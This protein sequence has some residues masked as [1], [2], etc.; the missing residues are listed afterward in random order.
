MVVEITATSLVRL[1]A[2]LQ[3]TTDWR[4]QYKKLISI[5]V[6]R[7]LLANS[8]YR[9]NHATTVK[10]Y[11]PYT[12]L[13]R[14]VRLSHWWIANFSAHRDFRLLR[15]INT[16]TYLLVILLL[17]NIYRSSINNT[18]TLKFSLEGLECYKDYKTN[19]LNENW[20][21]CTVHAEI[22][23]SRPCSAIYSPVTNTMPLDLLGVGKYR[24]F[25][26]LK[27]LR[28]SRLFKV[29]GNGTIR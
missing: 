21:Q 17:M 12:Q 19:C 29:I 16:L 15:L 2:V 24:L 25:M 9:L 3:G 11:Y 10:L 7:T 8:N 14:N 27:I 13:P 4:K 26:N 28:H 20:R 6:R 5:W 22:N 1:S 23:L 18:C